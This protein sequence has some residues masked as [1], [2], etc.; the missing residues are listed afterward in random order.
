MKILLIVFIL[1]ASISITISQQK[2]VLTGIVLD[3]S[4]QTFLKDINVRVIGTQFT[5]K[6]KEDGSFRITDIP[7]GTYQLEFTSVSYQTYV[8]TDVVVS[9]CYR[10]VS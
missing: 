3:I 9:T 10:R 5:A 6:S 7:V 4:T 2:G 1:F 8:Q